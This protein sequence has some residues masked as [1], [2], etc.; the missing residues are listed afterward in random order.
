MSVELCLYRA[1]QER[2]RCVG[3]EQK[4][5]AKRMEVQREEGAIVKKGICMMTVGR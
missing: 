2:G 3:V 4:E 1:M 5:G